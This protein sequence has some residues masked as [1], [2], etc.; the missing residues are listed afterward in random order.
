MA[1]IGQCHAR[2][3]EQGV[4]RIQTDIRVGTRIDKKQHYS[5]KVTA[6]EK[7]LAADDS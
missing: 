2:L 1:V 4:L 3:H 6:V 7:L 5:D